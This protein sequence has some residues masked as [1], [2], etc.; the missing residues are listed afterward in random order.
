MVLAA[1]VF[2]LINPAF[3]TL[4]NALLVLQQASIDAVA[5]IGLTLVLISGGI[6]ISQGSVMA[7]GAAGAAAAITTFGWA[8]PVAI[9]FGLSL[10]VGVGLFNGLFAERARIPAFIV[11][12]AAL[13]VVRG[14]VLIY[15]GGQALV[16][17]SGSA[18]VL[19][20]I[21]TG[22]AAG[23]PIAVIVTLG[24]YLI[25]AFI[26]HRTVWGLRTYA[27]GSS[28]ESASRAGVRTSRQR[29]SIYAV[30]G[31]M[32]ALAGLILLGRLGSAP[33]ELATGREFFVI[34]AAIVGGTSVYGGRG[35]LWRSC[36]GAAFIAM[37]ANGLVIANV[38]AFYQQ[39]AVGMVLIVALLLDRLGAEEGGH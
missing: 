10:G 4:D 19:R 33:S 26:M 32:S 13:F 3:F 23:I 16:L 21:G 14:L 22:R 11:T 5:A 15:L 25:G 27:V 6:D 35:K 8:E 12:L 28:A 20:A 18:P 2:G 1:A 36:L 29:V 38:P 30:A 9:A 7:L 37:L 17:P 34:T 24:L 39:V 31:L